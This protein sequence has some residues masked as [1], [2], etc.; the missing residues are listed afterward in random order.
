MHRSKRAE[1][2]M[3][4][5]KGWM[6]ENGVNQSQVAA[7]LGIPRQRRSG[8]LS[9]KE[10]TIDA[11]STIQEWLTSKKAKTSAEKADPVQSSLAST[12]DLDI[13]FEDVISF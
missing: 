11:F 9:G 3:K 1:A 10:P 5:L 12:E 4:D 2:L 7:E 6:K 8:W 13:S